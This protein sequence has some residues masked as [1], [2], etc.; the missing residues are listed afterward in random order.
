VGFSSFLHYSPKAKK[1]STLE[2]VKNTAVS[3]F[4]ALLILMP[5]FSAAQKAQNVLPRECANADFSATGRPVLFQ[6]RNGLQL[7]I[8]APP[9][10][11]SAGDPIVLDVWIVNQSESERLVMSC[12]DVDRWMWDLQI[13][14]PSWHLK[15]TRDEQD[16]RRNPDPA[17]KV[18]HQ[19]RVCYRNLALRVPP[20]SCSPL[21]DVGHV[22]T[23]DLAKRFD[24]SP[25][26]YFVSPKG[27]APQM[28][29]LPLTIVHK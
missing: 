26:N 16:E 13:Y 24:L 29:G 28:K 8:S 5:L 22:V 20:H 2:A 6:F 14:D 9:A 27:L 3:I 1:R 4:A 15:E 12:S 19:L 17:L 10:S 7:G 23:S 18:Q 21:Y 25:G 11:F